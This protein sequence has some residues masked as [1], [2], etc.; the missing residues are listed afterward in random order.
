MVARVRDEDFHS[1]RVEPLRVDMQPVSAG[2]GRDRIAGATEGLAELRDIDIDRFA[3]RWRR[4]LAPQ[5]VDQALARH[6][7]VR[8]QEQD[9]EDEALLECPESDRLSV[10]EHLERSEDPKLHGVVLPLRERDWKD[11]SQTV[12]SRS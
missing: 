9:A 10:L 7:L 3:G 6:E 8:V 5:I 2:G 4:R 12:L 1:A 11:P